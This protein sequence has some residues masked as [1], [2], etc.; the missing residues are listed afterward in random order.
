MAICDLEQSYAYRLMEYLNKKEGNPFIIKAFTT[1]DS[2]IEYT[3]NNKIEILLISSN[4]ILENTKIINTEHIIVLSEDKEMA[5]CLYEKAIYKYQSSENIIKEII[6]YYAEQTGQSNN[7]FSLKEKTKV[8][9]VYSPVSRVLKTSFALTIGQILAEEN[10][11][12]YVNMEGY[13]G[14][15]KLF[16]KIYDYDLADFMYY[17]LEKRENVIMKLA[18]IVQTIEGL[19]YIP[20]VNS[21]L[22]LQC[23]TAEE[24]KQLINLLCQ[25]SKYQI[26]IFDIGENLASMIHFLHICDK[27]YMPTGNDSSANAKI[28]QYETFI[29]RIG[30][31]KIL[32][33]T[34]KMSF[35]FMKGIEYGPEHLKYSELG[36]YVR[37]LLKHEKQ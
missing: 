8:L 37:E 16:D 9:G 29:Q 26:I 28:E 3:K 17:L 4:A 27:I 21:P 35:D 5:N 32:D 11:V 18:G 12:L 34:I 23:I 30:E 13:S 19:D 15:S 25:S 10:Q 7:L 1:I 33:K 20:P 6:C 14:F 31:E 22:D 36:S 2:L 24:W